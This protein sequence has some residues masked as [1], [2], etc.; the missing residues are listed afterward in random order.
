MQL[1][2]LAE[3]A[4]GH[5]HD[6]NFVFTPQGR[7]E[8]TS[9]PHAGQV[10][11]PASDRSKYP[12][13]VVRLQTEPTV[14]GGVVQELTLPAG[15]ADAVFWSDSAVHKFVVPYLASCAGHASTTRS[16]C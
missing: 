7:L 1:R 2:L 15:F 5:E 3:C 4:A 11:V 16:G 9:R 8:I 14:P 12:C 13:N 6:T 10:L